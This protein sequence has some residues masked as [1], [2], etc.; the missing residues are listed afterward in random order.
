[1]ALQLEGKLKG[2]DDGILFDHREAPADTDPTDAR[3]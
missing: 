1:V 2:D 3:R